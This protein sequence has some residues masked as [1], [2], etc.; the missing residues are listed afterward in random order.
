VIELRQ[1]RSLEDENARLKRLRPFRVLTVL[2]QWS[3]QSRLLEAASR[4]SG[5]T[6]GAA[7]DQTVAGGV[8]PQ[9]ITGPNSCHARSR[10]G[11][12]RVAS[13]S[14]SF[15]LGNPWKR[16]HQVMQRAAPRRVFERAP[17][18]VDRGCEGQD[19]SVASATIQRRPH[20]SL[21]HL[22]P[23]EY[24]HQRQNLEAETAAIHWLDLLRFGTNVN[25]RASLLSNCLLDVEA[26]DLARFRHVVELVGELQ[27][28][29]LHSRALR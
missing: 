8:T 21:G 19:R 17:I 2:D 7:L 1:L 25:R 16:L 14:S 12:S 15:D 26:Y 10:T 18:H 5:Q 29:E 23:N 3:Q 11:P 20:S 24:A 22:T 4:M 9:P 28:G 13:S 6:V 27:Q